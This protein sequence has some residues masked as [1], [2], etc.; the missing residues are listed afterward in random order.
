[1]ARR[2]PIKY[3]P[4]FTMGTVSPFIENRLCPCFF[5]SACVGATAG[6]VLPNPVIVEIASTVPC[7]GTLNPNPGMSECEC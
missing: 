4:A 1:M 7:V 2:Q 6:Y 3:K 5:K